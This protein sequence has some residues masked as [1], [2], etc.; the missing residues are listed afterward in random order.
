MGQVALAPFLWPHRFISLLGEAYAHTGCLPLKT[1]GRCQAR[2]FFRNKTLGTSW[3][4]LLHDLR[5]SPKI[6]PQKQK[7][8]VTSAAPTSCTWDPA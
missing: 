7:V 8:A 3:K 6:T 2:K 5:I 1:N 4:E